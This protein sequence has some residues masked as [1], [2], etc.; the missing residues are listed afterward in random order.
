MIFRVRNQTEYGLVIYMYVNNTFQG[1]H[2][3]KEARSFLSHGTH[4]TTHCL[5]N[6]LIRLQKCRFGANKL[7]YALS[8]ILIIGMLRRLTKNSI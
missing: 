5:Y 2:R 8:W 6:E 3:K 1:K 7:T 4:L